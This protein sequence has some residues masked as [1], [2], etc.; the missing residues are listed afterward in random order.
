MK[1]KRKEYMPILG[2]STS[3]DESYLTEIAL[4]VCIMTMTFLALLTITIASAV[5]AA[6]VLS[7]NVHKLLKEKSKRIKRL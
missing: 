6:T 4:I 7:T 3:D 2:D 1:G 5:T